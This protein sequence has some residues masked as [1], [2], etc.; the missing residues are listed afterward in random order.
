MAI[1]PEP[2]E[3]ILPQAHYVVIAQVKKIIHT[4]KQK[5]VHKEDPKIVGM[6]RELPAQRLLLH[7]I[8]NISSS[9]LPIDTDIEVLK[10]SGDYVLRQDI[11]GPFMLATDE[12]TN[13]LSIIGRY[14]PDSYSL[15]AIQS[16]LKSLDLSK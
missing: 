3:D 7:I 12:E 15:K 6:P 10:P 5:P 11:Q 16:T 9:T 4:D 8:E 2:I 14:G 1:P 13:Q